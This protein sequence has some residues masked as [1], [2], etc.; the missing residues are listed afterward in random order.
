[1]EYKLGEPLSTD[2]FID[3]LHRSSLAERRPV[4]DPERIAGMLRHADLTV[5][6]WDGS[7]LVGVARSV[8]D[9]HYCC[10]LS[11]LAVD[12]AYQRQGIGR[13]L[14]HKTREQ[15][16]PSCT[17]ILLAAPAAQDYYPRLGFTRHDSAWVLHPDNSLQ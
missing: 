8:T 11:D 4:E 10:Y 14:I 12:R 2:Q 17:L 1:M 5:T 15:L 7:L 3:L 6:A 16:G 9:F 13:Q